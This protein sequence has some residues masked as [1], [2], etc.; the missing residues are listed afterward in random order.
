M[1]RRVSYND[2]YKAWR[3]QARP[4]SRESIVDC[5]IEVLKNPPSNLVEE[6]STAPWLTLLMV[7]W[8]CQ[9]RHFDRRRHLP[10]ITLEQFNELRQGLWEFPARTLARDQESTPPPLFI[11]RLSRPQLGFQR[12]PNESFVREAALLAQQPDSHPLRALFK[13][14]TGLEVREFIEFALVTLGAVVTGRG[15][16]PVAWLTAI[17]NGKAEGVVSSFR[18]AVGRT[19]PELL[20]FCRSLP[21]AGY[22]VASEHFEFPF[23]TRYPFLR[24]GDVLICWH[25]AVVYR[26][27][28][29][30]VHSVLSEEGQ[31]YTDRFGHV[32]ERHV[33]AEAKKVPAQFFDEAELR[34]WIGADTKVPDGVLSFEGCNVFVESKAGLFGESMMAIGNGEVFAH[35]TR[36][37]RN[38]MAQ[39]WATSV[40]LRQGRRA[41]D[42]VGDADV[43]YLLVVTNKEL[44]VGK[45]TALAAMYPEGTLEP[46]N[47]EAA[48]LLPLQRVYL[49][50]IDDFER[51]TSGAAHGLVD[52]PEFL[53]SCVD[54]DSTP[55][56]SLFLFE[57]HLN[58]RSVP[59][60]FSEVVSSAI[61]AGFYRSEVAVRAAQQRRRLAKVRAQEGKYAG[62]S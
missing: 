41:P 20:A 57:Q 1:A 32:F 31:T 58:R 55:E 13:E 51:L 19:L 43:D 21:N 34:G 8:V 52:L 35:K 42:R 26:G 28:E 45:A 15:E 16:I 36:P 59:R 60:R 50:S 23:L 25:P 37:I 29:N 7:K 39:A 12:P 38:A 22:K 3:N 48:R 44:A 33:V 24:R 27:L 9:D 11:R 46:P 6:T 2:A 61:E 62:P 54:D 53:S 10:A 47:A 17:G 14:K 5:A 56:S 4:Y 18:S 49:L 30:F 40:S